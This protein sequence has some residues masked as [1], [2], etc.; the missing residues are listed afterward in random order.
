MQTF[1]H[2]GCGP[3][4]Q[5]QIPGFRDKNWKEIDLILIKMLNQIF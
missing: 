5:S 4:K 2:V 3:V 1:L